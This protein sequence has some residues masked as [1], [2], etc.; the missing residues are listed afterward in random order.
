MIGYRCLDF[1]VALIVVYRLVD[2]HFRQSAPLLLIKHC[3]ILD[4]NHGE[5]GDCLVSLCI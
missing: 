1:L 2:R 3:I 4:G 5:L